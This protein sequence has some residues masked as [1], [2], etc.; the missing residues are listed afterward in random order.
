MEH[1]PLRVGKGIR[2]HSVVSGDVNA[3][4]TPRKLRPIP[5]LRPK[6]PSANAVL[7]YLTRIDA[8]R[9]YSNFGPLSSEFQSRLAKLLGISPRAILASS[10]GTASLM[11]AILTVARTENGR[12]SLAV[13]PSFTFAATAV[14]AERCGLNPYFVDVDPVSWTID[15]AKLAN[16]PILKRAAIVLPVAPFGRPLPQAP[17]AEF[18][19]LTGV[20][21]VFDN[22]AAFVTAKDN[23]KLHFGRIPGV[24]SFHATKSFGIGEGGCVVCTDLDRMKGMAASINFGFYGARNSSV[25]SVNGKM[26]EY[27]AAVGLAALD[28][29]E[30]KYRAIKQA[31]ARYRRSFELAGLGDRFIGS[32]DID[33]SYA[34]F[35]GNSESEIEH[36]T[37]FFSEMMID[38]R[39][40]YGSGVHHHAHF[41]DAFREELPITEQLGRILLGIPMAPDLSQNAVDR[42]VSACRRGVIEGMQPK[43]RL[44]KLIKG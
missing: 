5:V 9:I 18:Q 43:R 14:S 44:L 12:R 15:P 31:A 11:A 42:V 34:I 24:F 35:Q 30:E 23:P 1:R 6:L 37:N 40:W 10:S 4:S 8:S 33:G 2:Y 26:S 13:M 25:A 29:W 22:A 32:P 19:E 28:H 3:A 38:Y 21:V 17:W 39:F 16:H 36:V 27:A 20:P 41:A 7:P